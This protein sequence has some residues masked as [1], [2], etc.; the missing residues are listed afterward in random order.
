MEAYFGNYIYFT[1]N[2]YFGSIIFK[3]SYNNFFI[4]DFQSNLDKTFTLALILDQQEKRLLID[5]K[6]YKN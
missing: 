5:T 2:L 1:N 6:K 3:R 4:S